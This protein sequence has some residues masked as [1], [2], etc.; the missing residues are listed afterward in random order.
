MS[1][2]PHW[3]KEKELRCDKRMNK[4][5]AAYLWTYATVFFSLVAF[6]FPFGTDAFC[7]I[8][9][10]KMTLTCV[11]KKTTTC[12]R[13]RKEKEK[14][15][16]SVSCECL[17]LSVC[18]VM[19]REAATEQCLNV[20]NEITAGSAGSLEQPRQ[21]AEADDT[22]KKR[23]LEVSERARGMWWKRKRK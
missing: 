10:G 9:S 8:S 21:A 15:R 19:R 23:G 20:I 2:F 18:S 7:C 12:A 17:C 5:R 14:K 22:Q 16:E 3:K 13:K 11:K 6:F 4:Q 1:S